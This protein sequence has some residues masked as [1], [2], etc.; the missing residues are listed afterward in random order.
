MGSVLILS[1]FKLLIVRSNKAGVLEI[2]ASYQYCGNTIKIRI[3]GT[4]RI[5]FDIVCGVAAGIEPIAS[6]S[7]GKHAN[8]LTMPWPNILQ[9]QLI[10]FSSYVC[11][12]RDKSKLTQ[13]RG[14]FSTL[15]PFIVFSY[16]C[17]IFLE[18][19]MMSLFTFR[20]TGSKILLLNRSTGIPPLS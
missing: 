1:L 9:I 11:A 2:T 8:H 7:R 6:Q 4:L 20:A 10:K 18:D 3:P 13:G 15:K 14:L 16:V 5:L 12:C 19:R 17:Y